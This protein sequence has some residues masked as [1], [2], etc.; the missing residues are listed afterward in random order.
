MGAHVHIVG[1][2]EGRLKKWTHGD[3]V[4]SSGSWVVATAFILPGNSGSPILDDNGHVVGLIHRG[5]TGQDLVSGDGVDEFSIGT[6]SSALVAAMHAPLPA[7]LH[8]TADVV[9]DEQAVERQRV[10]RNARFD[11]PSVGG[12]AK[13][14]LTSLGDACDKGLARTDYASPEDLSSALEP[15]TDAMDW[16]EC[17][18]DVAPGGYGVCPTADDTAKWRTRYDAVDAHY[19]ALNGQ[20][21]L[22]PI[23]FG[24]AALATDKATG[25]ADAANAL[26]ATLASVNPALDFGV[27]VYLAAFGVGSYGGQA[28]VD[29]TRGYRNVPHYELQGT[30]IVLTA[31]WLNQDQLLGGNDA[32]TIL[33]G[34]AGDDAVDLGT[35]LY[36]EE[37][38][39]DSK[40]I[41]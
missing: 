38:R 39:Y 10:Y 19:R 13:S 12:T 22:D 29:Y 30:D 3:V 17:R 32:N 35:K 14:I 24:R 34:L 1:H 8:S 28:L 15:C 37:I 5:P 7:A 33:T 4:D 27:A 41:D 36:V 23:T 2:P 40:L 31:L 21:A 11:S 6:A 25:K 9:T 26:N 20:M 16:I 18:S